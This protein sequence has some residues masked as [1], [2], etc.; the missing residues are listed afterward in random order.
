MARRLRELYAAHRYGC[1]DLRGSASLLGVYISIN[2]AVVA[3][4]IAAKWA[5]IGRTKPGRYPLWGVYYY[6]WWLARRF[7]GLVHTKWFQG[8]PLLPLYMKAIGAKI[9]KNTLLS[10]IDAGA[11]DLISVG[12]GASIGNNA[13]LRQCAGRRQ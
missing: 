6:R 9:G 10:E 7:L 2:I 13:V 11:M 3:I 8:S 12:D 4:A 1:V 5:I